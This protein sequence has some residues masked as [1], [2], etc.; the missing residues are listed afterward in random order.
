M[1]FWDP[2]VIVGGGLSWGAYE[3]KFDKDTKGWTAV[4]FQSGFGLNAH[5]NSNVS[6]GIDMR[7]TLPMYD[8]WI[9]NWGDNIV[10]D[11]VSEPSSVIFT[12]MAV[13]TFHVL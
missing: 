4:D 3:A 6:A 13:L 7:W 1:L 11:P 12:P 2:Y 10:A 8:E 5:F 9:F